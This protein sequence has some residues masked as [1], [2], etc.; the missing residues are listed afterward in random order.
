MRIQQSSEGEVGIQANILN[1]YD[2]HIP[3]S[4]E[5][6]TNKMIL[7]PFILRVSNK[8]GFGM[9]ILDQDSE[10]TLRNFT[11]NIRNRVW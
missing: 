2:Q 4:T 1:N 5:K 10:V 3:A 7:N 8:F 6:G 9:R 11:K